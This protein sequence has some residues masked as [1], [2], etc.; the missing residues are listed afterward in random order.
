M[1]NLGVK[2]SNQLLG[3][4]GERSLKIIFFYLLNEKF[5]SVVF[6]PLIT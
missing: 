5:V 1:R 6:Y 2:L 3:L 4:K